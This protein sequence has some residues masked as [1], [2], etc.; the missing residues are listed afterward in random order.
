MESFNIN[1]FDLS[2]RRTHSKTGYNELFVEN[3]VPCV[4]NHMSIRASSYETLTGYA[5]TYRENLRTFQVSIPNLDPFEVFLDAGDSLVAGDSDER[6][7]DLLMKK[8]EAQLADH[9][10]GEP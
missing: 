2:S 10:T 7:V 3:D 5:A 9:S 6:R 8:V 4:R 1:D